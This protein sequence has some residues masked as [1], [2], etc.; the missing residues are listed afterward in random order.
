MHLLLQMFKRWLRITSIAEVRDQQA[1]CPLLPVGAIYQDLCL[2][3]L[4]IKRERDKRTSKREGVRA[5][6]NTRSIRLPYLPAF[7]LEL[8]SLFLGILRTCLGG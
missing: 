5:Y 4:S 6:L 8:L 1:D 2:S 7:L 3:L